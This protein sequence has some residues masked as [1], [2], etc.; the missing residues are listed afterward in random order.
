MKKVADE[1]FL[2]YKEAS[3]KNPV[4]KISKVNLNHPDLKEW[5]PTISG[6]RTADFTN[7]EEQKIKNLLDYQAKKQIQSVLLPSSKLSFIF[8][9]SKLAFSLKEFE[10]AFMDYVKANKLIEGK[11]VFLNGY[12]LSCLGKKLGFS[13]NQLNQSNTIEE[14]FPDLDQQL[15]QEKKIADPNQKTKLK[16]LK[17]KLLDVLKDSCKSAYQIVEVDAYLKGLTTNPIS[18]KQAKCPEVTIFCD[19]VRNRFV[20]IVKNFEAFGIGPDAL[21]KHLSN[22]LACSSTINSVPSTK[23]NKKDRMVII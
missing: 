22:K 4:P 18:I 5:K 12:L 19:K 17:A 16:V 1:S 21:S 14:E 23:M 3:K 2:D 7:P 10:D 9:E 6:P 15:T 13:D 20:T 8:N 11:E